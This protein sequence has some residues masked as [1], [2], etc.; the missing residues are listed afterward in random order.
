MH[1]YRIVFQTCCHAGALMQCRRTSQDLHCRGEDM[2][3]CFFHIINLAFVV[4]GACADSGGSPVASSDNW[5]NS[6]NRISLLPTRS[7]GPGTKMRICGPSRGQYQPRLKPFTH[8]SPLPQPLMSAQV[9]GGCPLSLTSL[10]PT[11]K[12]PLQPASEIMQLH[13]HALL[14]NM[15]QGRLRQGS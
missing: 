3:G 1:A 7:R 13:H 6:S 11:A 2:R 8:S 12:E 15:R 14:D 5:A 4:G 9:S 10:V